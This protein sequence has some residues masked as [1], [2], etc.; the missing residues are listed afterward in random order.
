MEVQN[1]CCSAR[2][3][4]ER[5]KLPLQITEAQCECGSQLDKLGTGALAPRSSRLRSRALPMGRTLARVPEK[6]GPL[7]D[8]TVDCVT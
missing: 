2:L 7:S 4:L 6:Q 5:M 1:P 8:A 3:L